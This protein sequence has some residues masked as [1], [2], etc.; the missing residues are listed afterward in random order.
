MMP[1]SGASLT[2]IKH[3]YEIGTSELHRT[4]I[5]LAT[6]VL[7]MNRNVPEGLQLKA[8]RTKTELTAPLR[9]IN[10]LEHERLTGKAPL[11]KS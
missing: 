4:S 7:T 1:C 3:A 11:P 10:C 8:G 2:S 6:A 5:M 9:Q